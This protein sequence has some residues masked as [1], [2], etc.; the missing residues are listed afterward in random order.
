MAHSVDSGRYR[1]PMISARALSILVVVSI[2]ALAACGGKAFKA[3]PADDLAL[4]QRAVLTKADLPGYEAKPHTS[5]DDIPAGVKKDF[6]NCLGTP[7][8]IFDDTPGAQKADS[9]DF[10]QGTTQVSGS[11][12]IDPNKSDIDKG[13]AEISKGGIEPCLGKLFEAAV[14]QG[15]L[16]QPGIKVGLGTVKRFDVGVGDR[17]V[18]YSVDL[19]ITGPSGTADVFL[20]LVFVPRDRAGLD[21]SFTTVGTPF[22]RTVETALVQ[23]VYDRIGNHAR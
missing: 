12:E 14:K 23:K 13:W 22:D 17:S 3:S 4:A 20:D 15:A 5:N 7:T 9:P 8:S 18:G 6:A 21:F 2:V 10:S 1:F 16:D 19:Q 11:I